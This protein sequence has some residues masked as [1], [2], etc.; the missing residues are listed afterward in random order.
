MI[1]ALDTNVISYLLR[2]EGKVEQYFEREIIDAGNPYVIPPIV[3]YEL[4]RWLLDNPTKTL[5]TFA[6]VFDALYQSVKDEAV[7]TI[8][9]WERAADIYIT[10]KRRGELIGDS[11]ILIAAFCLVNDYTLVTNNVNDFERIDDLKIVNWYG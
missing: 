6:A 3:V 2:G 10:L 9:V 1:Y 4:K 7:M 5:T 11:D 8:D